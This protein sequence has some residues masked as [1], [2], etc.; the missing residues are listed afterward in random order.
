M[1]APLRLVHPSSVDGSSS[2]LQPREAPRRRQTSV[3]EG[4]R[5]RTID[6][7]SRLRSELEKFKVISAQ[8]R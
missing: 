3:L 1:K 4:E 2:L 7:S 6:Y 5:E 8:R